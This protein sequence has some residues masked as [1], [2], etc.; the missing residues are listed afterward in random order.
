MEYI[1]KSEEETAEKALEFV[2]KIIP[3]TNG[4]TVIGLYGE[5]GSGKSVFTRALARALGIEEKIQSPTF[6]IEKVYD[7]THKTF[8][9][10]FHLDVYRLEGP[11][12]LLPLGWNDILSDE[13]NLVV[14]EWADRV[15][16]IFP[17][18]TIKINFEHISENERKIKITN[19]N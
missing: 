19:G 2:K 4:A 15:E 3:R 5:L 10:F 12:E 9:K 13:C 14:V 16:E 11:A 17:G 8:K 6:V 1:T 18:D 7:L